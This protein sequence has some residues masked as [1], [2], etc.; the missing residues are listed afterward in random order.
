MIGVDYPLS[1]KPSRKIP[2]GA[3]WLPVAEAVAF[4]LDRE[5]DRHPDNS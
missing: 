3:G 4:S 2:V 5:R 1:G